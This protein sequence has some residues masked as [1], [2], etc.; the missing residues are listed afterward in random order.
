MSNPSNLYAEKVFSE[1]PTILWA[2]DD[3]ADYIS[4]ITEAQRDISD[5][6]TVTNGT[7]T[8]SFSNLSQP[9]EDSIL[10]LISGDVPVGATQTVTAISPN[11]INF[12]NLNGGLGSFSIGTYFYNNSAYLTDVAIG[13][14]YTDTTTG[15]PVQE[16]QNF[17]TIS[18]Q[19][20]SFVSGTFDIP[21][22]NT[23]FRI[24]VSFTYTSGGDDP[25]DYQFF[26]NGISAGQWSE[27]FNATSLGVTPISLPS[28]IALS[29]DSVIS[30]DPYGLGG[31]V[32]YY[33]VENN[34]LVARNSG[35]P[36]VYG[37]SGVTRLTPNIENKPS[38]IVPG[39][40][41]LNKYGQYKEYTVEFWARINSNAYTP[42][43][44]FGPIAST[45]GLYV[46]SGFLTLVI[47]NKFASHFV[48]EWFRPM[49]IH[50]RMIRN[51]ATVLINGEEVI[52]LNITT[53]TLTLP[54]MVDAYGDSQDWLGFY[55]YEDVTPIEI[56]CVAI[57]PYSVAVNV[58]KRRWVY[59]QGVLSPEGI[60][61]AY[62]G[63]SAFI[64]Y[65]FADYTGNYT[66]PDFA[67]W[68]QGSFDN[69]TTTNTALTTPQYN[70]PDIFLGSKTLQELYDDNKLIQ[71]PLDDNFVTFRPD[72]SWNAEECYFNFP[73]F[74]FLNDQIHTIYGVFSSNDLTTEETLF[75]IY[76][77]LTGNFFSIRKDL[78]EIHYY[79]TYNGVEEEIYTTDIIVEDEKFSAGIEIQAL[80][81]YF[82][83]NVAAFFGSQNGLQMYVGGDESGIYQFT[84]KIYSV[85]LATSYNANEISSHFDTNGIAILDSHLATGSA[86]SQNAIELLAHTASYTLLP[87][88]A[89]DTYFLD[90]GVS[91]YWEDY[92]PLSYFAQYITNDVGNQ[93]YDLDFLQFN[94]GYP[95]PTKLAEYETTG[96]WT[97]GELKEEYAH[98]VQR[99]YYQLDNTLFT[100]WNNYEDMAQKAIK[101]FEYDTSNAAVRSYITF[102]YIADGA[103]S[104]QDTFSTV[105]PAKEGGIIDMDLYPDW[106]TTKFEVVDNTLVYPT[107][108]IDFNE[109]AIVYHLE[110]NIRGILTKPIRLRR[111]EIASQAFNDNA[112]N[113]IGTRFGINMFPYKRSGLYYD[114]KAKNP[115]SIYKGSTP[116]LYL[117]RTSGIEV[118]GDFDP[119]T[120]RGLAIP[121]NSN[122]ADNYRVSAMQLWMRYDQDAF[123]ITATEIFEVR[124]KAD[125]IKFYMIA[126]NPEGTR[127]RILAKSQATGQAYNGLSYFINGSIVREPVLTIKEWS[128]LGI[129]FATS[130]N[131]DLFV[132]G[133]NLNG[134]LVFNNVAYYQANN[135]QQVQSNLTRPWLRV[136]TD[137][138][139]NFDWEYWVNNYV[140]EGVLVISASE[141]YGV[142]PSDVYKTY[143]GTNKIIIDDNEGMMFDAE[144]VKIYNDTTWSIR[145]GSAV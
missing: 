5:G 43:R 143:I 108:T 139:T 84:G 36:M 26:V 82:G 40:G 23:E 18:F 51:N 128:V 88:Q 2:L 86:E 138:F 78:D 102:Q 110:F 61:S 106:L 22:E 33:I 56:D 38:L 7:A 97:Y 125:T 130:L 20:W 135:L 87:S 81:E 75:K 94:L 46:E 31:D 144:K 1:H 98:P 68:E 72:S 134:P 64:D 9:F 17:P 53:D 104:P 79:L 80:V 25:V 91:G 93:Y 27:E 12:S 70:L 15:N 66:Y 137:G 121:I 119:L 10:N 62:G 69:L 59:G 89:Y 8:E 101:Y 92:L 74:N 95:S 54:D 4:L 100:G 96:S 47:G 42:K 112:F 129:A 123:P 124:Y 117:T 50:V 57:Y 107:K 3:K 71:D 127:A 63:S 52:N 60:N 55:A 39:K 126:D 32:G 73:R 14:E 44:I 145:V 131:F 35:I 85:G 141:I 58:A 30:A 41:F 21:I 19:S 118:R 90:I 29:V 105:L 37:A 114:Y 24:V 49:L 142:T 116:Y 6:W 16:L 76:N 103:N 34:A 11:L 120:S 133:I 83:G 45:D 113:P 13:F 48:G 140:W 28:N 122:I 65:P 132:G 109:L 67:Q 111:L 115:F 77:T 99:T 136:K